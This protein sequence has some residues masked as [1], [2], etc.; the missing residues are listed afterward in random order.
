MKQPEQALAGD[1]NECIGRHIVVSRQRAHADSDAV[2]IIKV[3]NALKLSCSPDKSIRSEG[4]AKRCFILGIRVIPPLRYIGV[5][6]PLHTAS[7]LR[8]N[9]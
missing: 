3:L 2:L 4:A 1:E 8:P 6:P 9:R 7:G 5:F